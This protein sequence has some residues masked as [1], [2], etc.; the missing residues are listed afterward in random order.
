MFIPMLLQE[1][2]TWISRARVTRTPPEREA[3]FSEEAESTDD[4]A[5][6]ILDLSTNDELADSTNTSDDDSEYSFG[7]ESSEVMDDIM[8]YAM[9]E[10]EE[11]ALE[12]QRLAA[13]MEVFRED[14]PARI[15]NSQNHSSLSETAS[16]S[17]QLCQTTTG[18]GVTPDDESV[19]FA[20]ILRV[21]TGA[22]PGELMVIR[23]LASLWET[24]RMQ[25]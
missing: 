3:T 2:W 21:T 24:G 20:P 25:L 8:D 7:F 1:I 5:G 15:K 4:P 10:A 16:S 17:S 9:D 23:W 14:L 18:S 12:T 22:W 6:K 11:T 13:E 19:Q